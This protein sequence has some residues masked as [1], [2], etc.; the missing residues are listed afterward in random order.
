MDMVTIIITMVDI[1]EI[2]MVLDLIMPGTYGHYFS[3]FKIV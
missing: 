1:M 2:T 3:S